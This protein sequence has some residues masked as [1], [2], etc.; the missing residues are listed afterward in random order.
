MLRLLWACLRWDD[1]A[2]KPSA[3]SG[4]TRT[5][6]STASG[7]MYG[8]FLVE[9]FAFF[10]GCL[11]HGLW[12]LTLVTIP[13]QPYPHSL[14]QRPRKLKSPPPRSSSAGTWGPTE[15]ARSTASEKSSA[16]SECPRLPKVL[17]YLQIF[18]N[19]LVFISFSPNKST[20]TFFL[21][22]ASVPETHTPQRK[23]LRSSALRPKKQ[24]PAKQT[25]PVVIE[26]WVPEEELDLWE[27]RAFSER[28][29]GPA[30]VGHLETCN[31]PDGRMNM[32][33]VF[34]LSQGGERKGPGSRTSEGDCGVFNIFMTS[35]L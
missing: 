27:I 3:G 31:L 8:G 26:T 29:D 34:F 19:L 30:G 22:L 16:L 12:A 14:L 35:S 2:V 25:G 1:M 32:S 20:N 17:I 23:G 15:F 24:E 7:P 21:C 5:G 9:A 13:I 33:G 10:F 28:S 6:T 18:S 11:L 4:T